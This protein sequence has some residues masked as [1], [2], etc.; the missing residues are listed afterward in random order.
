MAKYK[1]TTPKEIF[2]STEQSGTTSGS[3]N[4]QNYPIDKLPSSLP[5]GNL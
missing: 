1:K 2:P 3:K 4:A 5:T